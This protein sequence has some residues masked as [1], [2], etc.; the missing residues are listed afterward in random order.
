VV[1]Y[2]GDG[3]NDASSLRAAD[4]GISVE[5]AVDVA[6]ESASI[7]LLNKD[8]D[9]LL[10]GI[11]EGRTTF[12]NTLKYMMMALSSNFGNMLSLVGA[13]LFL[14]FLPIL[15]V[16][17]L[18]NNSLYD[19]SQIMIPTDN[20]DKEQTNTPQQ[21]N[22]KFVRNF[23]FIFGALSTVFDL[24]TFYLMYSILDL[25]DSA[26][27]TAW[28]MTSFFSQ[29]LVIYILRTKKF[30]FI[31]SKPSKWL[32]ANSVVVLSVAG[33]IVFSSLGKDF[34]F[35]SPNLQTTLITGLIITAYL[36]C[37]QTAKIWFYKSKYEQ[38]Q[39]HMAPS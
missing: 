22:I 28:F 29:I 14:P 8:F 35:S 12:A 24:F 1:G 2:L 38:V 15:P 33:G 25:K 16:Q 11:L 17:I 37:I 13:A 36:A 31:Q 7:I 5:N 20:V 3:I 34:G 30:P 21:W 9:S 27:Q 18:L 10:D 6:R 19:I 4:V 32:V 39:T 26:F 23:M